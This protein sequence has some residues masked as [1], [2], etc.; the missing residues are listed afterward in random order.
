[1]NENEF[2]KVIEMLNW[3][4]AGDDDAVVEPVVDYLSEKSNDDIF[5]F[6]ELLS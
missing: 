2:W 4:E 5:Q 6:E 3:D 1:M